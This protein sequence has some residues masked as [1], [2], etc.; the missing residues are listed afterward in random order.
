MPPATKNPDSIRSMT[1]GGFAVGSIDET[2]LA[3]SAEARRLI[4][5]LGGPIAAAAAI[6]IDRR[7]MQR[8]YRGKRH[9]SP[10]L[11]RRLADAREANNG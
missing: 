11:I 2:E 9:A 6:D 7:T 8:I 5:A 3:R 1:G 10:S 4:D